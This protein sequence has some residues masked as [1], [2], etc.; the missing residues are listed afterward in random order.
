M[1]LPPAHARTIFPVAVGVLAIIAS[2]FSFVVGF[3]ALLALVSNSLVYDSLLLLMFGFLGFALGLN[4]GINSI[5]RRRF[6]MSMLCL[7]FLLASGV[8]TVV[9]FWPIAYGGFLGSLAVGLPMIILSNSAIIFASVS[10]GEFGYS[11]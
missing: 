7:C 10:R 2:C 4:G 5:K 6:A 8:V 11:G 3:F 9:D 1:P